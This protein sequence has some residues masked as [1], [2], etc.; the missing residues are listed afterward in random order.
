MEKI[1]HKIRECFRSEG[2]EVLRS[3]DVKISY[4]YDGMNRLSRIDY[5]ETA[6]T[7][8]EY[9]STNTGKNEAGKITRL[10]D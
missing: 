2:D 9:G 8:Y 1:M 10:A 3:K 6:D 4:E 7:V 5:P